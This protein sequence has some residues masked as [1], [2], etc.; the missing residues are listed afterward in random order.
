MK[1]KKIIIP[2]IG[3][4]LCIIGLVLSIIDKDKD[5]LI[6]IIILP[7]NLSILF[8]NLKQKSKN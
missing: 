4:I 8:S 6:Y 2:I 7:C 3:I 1:N 5:I